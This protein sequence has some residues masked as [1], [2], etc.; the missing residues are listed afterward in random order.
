ME[1][2][3]EKVHL[4]QEFIKRYLHH[5]KME[6]YDTPDYS[7]RSFIFSVDAYSSFL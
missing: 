4:H 6:Q 1:V 7:A 2:G 3:A 5:V